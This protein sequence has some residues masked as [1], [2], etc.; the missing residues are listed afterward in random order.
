MFT[1]D[2]FT[3][4]LKL[5]APWLVDR[6]EIHHAPEEAHVWLKH[7]A[8]PFV[9][10]TCGERC[11]VHDHSRERMWRHLDLWQ[12]RTY[13]HAAMPRISCPRHGVLQVSIPWA[14]PHLGMTMDMECQVID[15][16]LA[17]KT[18]TSACG[19]L[20]MGWDQVR[21]VMERAVERGVARRTDD[22]LRYIGVDEKA[23]LKRH[24]YVTLVYDLERKRVVEVMPERTES[25]LLRYWKT[26]KA[27]ALAKIEVIAMDMWDPFRTATVKMVPGAADK[28][29]HDRFH[30]AMHMGKAVDRVRIEEHRELLMAED[31]TLSGTKHCWLYGLENLPEHLCD[32]LERLV[33]S[34]LRTA[35]AWV[36]KEHLRHLWSMP[37]VDMAKIFAIG[38]AKVAK[39]TGLKPVIAVANLVL[40]HLDQIANFARNRITN[41]VAEGINSVVMTLQR[42]A[43]GYRSWRTF[44]MAIL[45]FCGGLD[46]YPAPAR[47]TACVR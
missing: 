5:P 24:K 13:I 10:P 8:G 19:E 28:I 17:C 30:V 44:R 16:V 4:L 22:Q 14:T 9:C 40:N 43:R 35:Q 47:K 15:L 33:A 11:P 3:K 42:A 36:I 25:S 6:M 21:A 26:W 38:W 18:V 2:A 37:T 32:R 45:F 34:D 12:C 46:L 7:A 29:V 39:E 31:E 27:A 23:L 1:T 41:A 20:R